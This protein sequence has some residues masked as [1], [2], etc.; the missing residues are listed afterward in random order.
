VG[1]LGLEARDP[2]L[3][4]KGERQKV[5]VASILALRPAVLIL[6]EPTTGLDFRE[7]T[8]LMSV[9]DRLHRAGQ[10][11]VIITHVPWVVGTYAE[12]AVLLER[13]RVLYDG[14]VGSLFA[15]EVLCRNADFV[16]PEAARLANRLGT[17]AVDVEGL[18]ALVE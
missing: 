8:A 5:A 12:R 13:G 2:F 11:V 4:T 16:P 17:A 18:W 14:P 15:D 3:L 1:L 7:L 6:D 10:T 9:L